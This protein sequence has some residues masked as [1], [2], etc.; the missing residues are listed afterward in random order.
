[1]ALAL[2]ATPQASYAFSGLIT[3]TSGNAFDAASPTA[4]KPS[5]TSQ[6]A[7]LYDVGTNYPN[8]IKILPSTSANNFTSVGMRVVGW[9]QYCAT[10][11][12]N[13]WL[14]TVLADV[15]LGYTTGTVASVSVDGVTNFFFS[16]ATVATGVPTVNIYTPATAAGA[17]V[18]P[19]SVIIDCVGSTLIQVQ[20]KA[21]GTTPKMGAFWYTI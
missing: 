4:T 13:P 1:M 10:S 17:N 14:P 6:S 20:F 2:A 19:A 16:T 9:S 18:Q 7:L 21:T 11:G 15:T 12:S 5:T 3:L 8:L